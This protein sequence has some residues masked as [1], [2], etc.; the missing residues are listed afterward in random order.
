MLLAGSTHLHPG[1]EYFYADWRSFSPLMTRLTFFFCKDGL[2]LSCYQEHAISG[3]NS[4]FQR[5]TSHTI[6]PC[7]LA[8]A[9]E[10]FHRKSTFKS[11][12]HRKRL[13]KTPVLFRSHFFLNSHKKFYI[14]SDFYLDLII[15]A[16][17]K[18]MRFWLNTIDTQ[19]AS[20]QVRFWFYSSLWD[21]ILLIKVK[22]LILG[23]IWQWQWEL[24]S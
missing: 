11:I 8:Q 9:W 5:V 2:S 1:K 13:L 3:K 24:A 23:E 22:L 20:S 16:V 12:L 10:Q 7:T 15:S 19:A 21:L 17:L 18:S 4:F 6:L 14:M